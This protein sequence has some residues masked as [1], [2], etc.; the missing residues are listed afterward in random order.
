[1]VVEPLFELRTVAV[2]EDGAFSVF[3]HHPDGYEPNRGRPFAVTLE[4]TF[5]TPAPVVAIR[6]VIENGTVRCTKDKFNRGGYE[7]FLLHVPG[8]D[9]VLFHRGNVET[10]SAGCVL[11]AES[12]AVIAGNVAV[13]QS[14]D[15][16]DEFWSLAKDLDEFFLVVSGR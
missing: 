12:F 6:T 14:R 7:T 8:H 11:V 15:G 5:E 2:R 9:R 16:F 13:A 1:M 10:D 3:L 4:R